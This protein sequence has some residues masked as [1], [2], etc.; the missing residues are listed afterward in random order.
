MVDPPAPSTPAP[1]YSH[2][3]SSDS[4]SDLRSTLESFRDLM[5]PAREQPAETNQHVA[6]ASVSTDVIR[7]THH[8]NV[9]AVDAPPQQP[10]STPHD[11]LQHVPLHSAATSH[12][13]KTM[14]RAATT[15]PDRVPST[16][17]RSQ[18]T[19]TDLTSDDNT[20]VVDD[21]WSKIMKA[22]RDYIIHKLS[23]LSARLEARIDAPRNKA[24]EISNKRSVFDKRSD[25]YFFGVRF[26]HLSRICLKLGGSL[27][28]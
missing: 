4:V 12:S 19:F 21:F 15:T 8:R 1:S 20:Q 27:L 23:D 11:V 18:L 17:H 14:A 6:V 28:L 22:R 26:K 25:I 13:D 24:S 10:R 5:A 7:S 9:S 2:P 16:Q 3:P